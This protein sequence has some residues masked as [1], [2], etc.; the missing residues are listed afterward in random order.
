MTR[1]LRW[2]RTL[3]HE[4]QAYLPE[5]SPRQRDSITPA[6]GP[7][8]SGRIAPVP[9]EPAETELSEEVHAER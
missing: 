3:W 8:P 7:R 6:S 9:V 5:L 4:N 2:I 1:N